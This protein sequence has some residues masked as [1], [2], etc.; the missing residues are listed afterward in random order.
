MSSAISVRDLTRVF[1]SFTAVD[2]L[3][4]DVPT[5]SIVGFLG[6]NGA[7]KSTTIRML[8]GEIAPTSG[9]ATVLGH[10]VRRESLEIHARL[11]YV[12]GDLA[13]YPRMTGSELLAFLGRLRGRD[14]SAASLRLAKRLD[15]QLDRP[16]GH[17]STGNRQKIGLL[18]ALVHEPELL[19]L[20]EPISGLDPLVQEQFHELLGE[21][22][23]RGGTTFL[24][25]H[26]LS[27][28][29]RVADSVA[30]L[31]TGRLV[32]V[33]SVAALLTAAASHL[34]VRF[35]SE[36]SDELVAALGRIGEVRVEH[37]M[38]HIRMQGAV[39]P[40]LK[41]LA[42]VEVLELRTRDADLEDVFLDYYRDDAVPA[43]E[44][45]P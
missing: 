29:E 24:S 3:D 45:K 31:R 4:L 35:A 38:A 21:H 6:P 27:E 28:V 22:R 14:D 18:Q 17:L 42:T 39:D 26:T 8:L 12:P 25:S 37:D 34:D 32:T 10:D 43:E 5:G 13:L 41:L 9:T 1:G 36:P 30:V 11:G 19:I 33:Q 40:L 23:D 20:D 7:G 44:A 2:S 16:L 15:A